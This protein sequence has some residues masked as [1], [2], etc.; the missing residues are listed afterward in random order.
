MTSISSQG[1]QRREVEVERRRPVLPT[2]PRD[3]HLG[4]RADP[5]VGRD[6]FIRPQDRP[7]RH[8]CYRQERERGRRRGELP[9]PVLQ[10]R[11]LI[12]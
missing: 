10:V 9:P 11:W 12:D 1:A 5:A 6:I 7:L 3:P 8:L 2:D 4:V